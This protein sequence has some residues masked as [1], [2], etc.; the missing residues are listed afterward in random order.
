MNPGNQA[1]L[2]PLID[3][4]NSQIGTA[5]N[6]TNGLASTVLAFTPAQLNANHEL[7][8]ASRSSAQAAVGALQKGRSDVSQI[9][10]DLRGL[11]TS[12]TRGHAGL[13]L[14]PG[15]GHDLDYDHD[16][17]TSGRRPT[18][19]AAPPG[20]EKRPHLRGSRQRRRIWVRLDNTHVGAGLPATAQTLDCS[21]KYI[22]PNS[23]PVVGTL[24]AEAYAMQ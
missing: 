13:D 4:L 6:A 19:A 23:G 9:V 7:L 12:G 2:Q 3:D 18:G 20:Q 21:P 8:A 24:I 14:G 17:L 5:T 1:Q 10:Q 16:Q 11:A 15:L 22:D